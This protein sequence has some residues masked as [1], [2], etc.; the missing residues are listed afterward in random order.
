MSP[1]RLHPITLLR[2]VYKMSIKLLIFLFLKGGTKAESQSVSGESVGDPFLEKKPKRTS[3]KA[4]IVPIV[5]RMDEF[6]HKV[7]LLILVNCHFG[8][9]F[10]GNGLNYVFISLFRHSWKS[11]LHADQSRV[12]SQMRYGHFS[13][14]I[15]VY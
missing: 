9:E 3:A 11:G 12:L 4:I 6:D 8:V 1:Q 5:L 2:L 15:C 14:G 7:I 10:R 13:S